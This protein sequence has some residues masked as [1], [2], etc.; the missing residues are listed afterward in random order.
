MIRIFSA[1]L[2]QAEGGTKG[3]APCLLHSRAPSRTGPD[4]S[5]LSSSPWASLW[6]RSLSPNSSRRSARQ[7]QRILRANLPLAPSPLRVDERPDSLHS[8]WPTKY[9]AARGHGANSEGKR[10]NP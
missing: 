6:L 4:S 9:E 1:D 10:Q 7:P 8:E 5:S 2:A 3:S